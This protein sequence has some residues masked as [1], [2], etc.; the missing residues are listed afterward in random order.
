MHV[1]ARR[2]CGFTLIELLVVMA[3]IAVLVALLVP[4]VQRAREAASRATCL[5]NLRQIAIAAHNRSCVRGLAL[6]T[7]VKNIDRLK[8]T[9]IGNLEERATASGTK[10]A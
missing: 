8:H 4:A 2:R 7:I 1:T 5:N 9:A 6:R 10:S 3:I